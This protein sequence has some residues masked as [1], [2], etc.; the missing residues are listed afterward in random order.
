MEIIGKQRL[1]PTIFTNRH[2][3]TL[4]ASRVPEAPTRRVVPP[5]VPLAYWSLSDSL[6]LF[7][8]LPET[9]KT[10]NDLN[11]FLPME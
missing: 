3:P 10:G 9:C 4:R 6:S 2:S 7:Q 8:S 1:T 11:F 5:V